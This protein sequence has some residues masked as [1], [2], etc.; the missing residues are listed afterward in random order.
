MKALSKSFKHDLNTFGVKERLVGS[1]KPCKLFHV[2]LLLFGNH[3]GIASIPY[4]FQAIFTSF[5]TIFILGLP[6]NVRSYQCADHLAL[7]NN[8][9]IWIS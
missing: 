3:H 9:M 6:N 5:I 1:R 4:Y 7:C 8:D 2:L